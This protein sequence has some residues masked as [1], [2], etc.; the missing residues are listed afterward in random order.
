MTFLELATEIDKAKAHAAELEATV[1]AA[2][3]AFADAKGKLGMHTTYLQS[4]LKDMQE[5]LGIRVPSSEVA[6]VDMKELAK[7][8][9]AFRGSFKK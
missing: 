3:D 4:L 9:Q 6:D 2:A 7:Q 5:M 8:G 1:K